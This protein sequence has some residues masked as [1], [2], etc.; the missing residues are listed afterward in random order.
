MITIIYFLAVVDHQLTA[1]MSP[2]D[3][4]K[5]EIQDMNT[6]AQTGKLPNIS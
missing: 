4:E 1:E 2:C 5:Q 6:E 3:I